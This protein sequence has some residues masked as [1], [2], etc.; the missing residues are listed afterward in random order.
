M[1]SFMF[2][3]GPGVVRGRGT[4]ALGRGTLLNGQYKLRYMKGQGNLSFTGSFFFF[5]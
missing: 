2:Y 3:V 1:A 5:F 4:G